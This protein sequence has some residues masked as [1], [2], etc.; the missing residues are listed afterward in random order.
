MFANKRCRTFLALV[1]IAAI[2]LSACAAPT[3]EVVEKQVVV[4]KPVVETVVIEKD[5]VV[6]VVVTAT[7]VTGPQKGGTL[8]IGLD[9]ELSTLDPADHRERTVETVVRNMFDGLV[10]RTTDGRVVLELAESATLV[11]DTTWEF[12]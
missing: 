5:V 11:D 6:E 9:A 2:T 4:E 10:T 8:V 7:P 3:P 12:V 1:A